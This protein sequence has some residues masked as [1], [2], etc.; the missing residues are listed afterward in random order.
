MHRRVFD[1]RENLRLDAVD[2]TYPDGKR[3]VFDDEQDRDRNTQ[4]DDRVENRITEVNTEHPDQNR[5]TGESTHACVLTVGHQCSRSN[6]APDPDA[7]NR[8]S[9]VS[10]EA[11]HGRKRHPAKLNHWL[12]MNNFS[13]R[14]V[15]GDTG[16]K[17][18]GENNEDAGH[19]FGFSISVSE[20]AA[21]AAPR[22]RECYPKRN[23]C[24]R[25]SEV[26]NRVR[27]QRDRADN[28]TMINCST[29]VIPS[30]T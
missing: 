22:Q 25:I 30:A 18:N 4:A 28:K 19:V 3:G 27:K 1:L 2:Q 14:F 29:A 26:V 10:E 23:A 11:D 5:Q 20:T 17:E 7:E 12:R 21:G 16:G 9:F 13:N 6:F 8:N 24:A 15:C